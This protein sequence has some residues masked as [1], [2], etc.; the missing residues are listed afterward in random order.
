MSI[1]KHRLYETM[2][3][4]SIFIKQATNKLVKMFQQQVSVRQKFRTK[5]ILT[6]FDSFLSNSESF[7]RLE[8]FSG[9]V[10]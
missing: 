3:A 4:T 5:A 8:R 9:K 1:L 10:F 6:K 2:E 7:I